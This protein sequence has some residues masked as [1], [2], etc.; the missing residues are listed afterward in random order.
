MALR[1][2]SRSTRPTISLMVRKPSRAMISRSSSA[3]MKKKLTTCSG[4]PANFLRSSGSCVATPTGQVFRWHLRI[5]MQPTVTR[6]AVAMPHSSAPSIVAMAMSLAVRNWPSVCT[7]IR[8]R[9]SLSTS[10]W[11]VSARPSSQGAPACLIEVCGLAPVPPSCPLISTTSALPLADAGGDRAHADLGH[12]FDADPRLAVGVLQVVDQLRQVLDRIDV[13]MRRRRDQADARRAV[14]DAGDLLVDL[15]AGQLAAFAR[16]GPLRHFDLQLSGADQVFA[17][18][19]EAAAG[20]LLDGAGA[21]VAVGIGQEADR[22]FAPF[23]RVASPADAVH[24][25]GQRLVRFARDRAVGHGAGGEALDD[26]PRPFR[27]RPT[28]RGGPPSGS[29]ASPRSV[30]NCRCC[31]SINC[32]ELAE[33]VAAVDA[34]VAA[35]AWR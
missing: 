30:S 32:A 29:P 13:V 7:T 1:V 15:V 25:D 8:P 9:R 27:L 35:A 14:A 21:V 20:D 17:G 12:Q 10:T 23:A 26:R 2:S 4:L 24:G 22:V 31:S 33:I 11:C 28:V 34:V 6:A 3:S 19:A 18:H 5:M 16:L